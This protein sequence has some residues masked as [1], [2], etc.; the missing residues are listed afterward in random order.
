[1][2][3]S[4]LYST[5]VR[6]ALIC[7][8]L[9]WPAGLLVSCQMPELTR[10]SSQQFP[11]PQSCAE[12]HVEISKEWEHSPHAAA[13]ASE[14]YR[15]A[16]D[17]YRFNE[18]LGCHAPQPMLTLSEPQPRLT[19]RELGVTCA[20]CHLDHGAMVGPNQPTGF[21]KPHPIKV[22]SALFEDGILCGRCHQGTLAQWRSAR[23]EHKQDCR[24]CHMP[25]VRR[26]MTQATTLISRPIVAAEVPATEHRHVF[27]LVPTDLPEKPFDLSVQVAPGDLAVTL[28]NHLPHDL[29]T[30]DFGVRILQVTVRGIDAAGKESVLAQWEVTGNLG[31]PV[32]PGGS[33]CWHIAR[34]PGVRRLKLEM[35]RRGSGPADQSLLLRKEV[36]LP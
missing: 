13:F 33:R 1:M 10:V 23:V 14:S 5:S 4:K 19:E 16:T 30:G 21:V 24:Q 8:A 35:V 26:T 34:P 3:R 12:C 22:D 20:S 25:S 7:V 31:G 36:A 28:T 29:P 18:C 17:G 11:K 32:P 9:G 2:Y 27:T 6:A 15:R